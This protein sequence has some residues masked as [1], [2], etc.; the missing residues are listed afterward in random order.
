MKRVIVHRQDW[1]G[2]AAPIIMAF[3]YGVRHERDIPTREIVAILKTQDGG[4]PAQEYKLT[5]LAKDYGID[6][7]FRD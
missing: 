5:K 1:C 7:A 4:P 6:L 2:R 3:S